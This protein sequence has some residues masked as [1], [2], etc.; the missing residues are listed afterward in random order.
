MSVYVGQALLV[1]KNPNWPYAKAAH[2]LADTEEELH[3]FAINKLKLKREWFQPKSYPHYDVT[4]NK[5]LQALQQGAIPFP[6]IREE[7]KW[8]NDK[9]KEQ[10]KE[11]QAKTQET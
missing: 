3:V 7:G 9:R 6:S 5:R 2:L 4:E 11:K 1:L 10:I 8:L